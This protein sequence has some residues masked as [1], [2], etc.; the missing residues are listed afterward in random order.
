MGQWSIQ[1]GDV[2]KIA[3]SLSADTFDACFCDPPYALEFMGKD[4][5]RCLPGVE[6]WG[7]ILRICKPGAWLLA[8]GGTRTFHRL[9]C[10]IEDAGWTIKDCIMWLHSMG[11]PKSLDLGK[12]DDQ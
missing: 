5:D 6:V 2:G 3:A 9:A 1:V 12:A 7:E 4:W 10:N 11:F 8:F